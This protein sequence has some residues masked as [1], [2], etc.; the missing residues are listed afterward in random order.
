LPSST[1]SVE[2]YNDD[3]YHDYLIDSYDFLQKPQKLA[4]ENLIK[5]KEKSKIYYKG[6]ETKVNIDQYNEQKKI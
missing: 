4:P 5:S 1:S 2:E 3:T 6:E